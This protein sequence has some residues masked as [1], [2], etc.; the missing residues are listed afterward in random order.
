MVQNE[1]LTIARDL[2]FLDSH[3]LDQLK[4]F[5]LE[6]CLLSREPF[7]VGYGSFSD[8]YKGTCLVEERGE[9]M[10]AMK[11]L[12]LHVDSVNCKQVSDS[13]SILFNRN[14]G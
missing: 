7:A 2:S 13:I 5:D 11:R 4:S 6:G 14:E 3:V 9:V 8:V 1:P 10:T 12:R